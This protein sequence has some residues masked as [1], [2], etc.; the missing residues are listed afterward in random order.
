VQARTGR[1]DEV[2]EGPAIATGV[3]R[4]PHCSKAAAAEIMER[5]PGPGEYCPE[6]GEALDAQPSPLSS[7]PSAQAR[8]A[9]LWRSRLFVAPLAIA[10][11]G[12]I[13]FAFL[14][15]VTI[16]RRP[17]TGA[18]QVCRSSLTDRIAGDIVRTFAAKSGTAASRFAL[19]SGGACDLRFAAGVAR[20]DDDAVIGHDGIV[21]VVNRRNSV[22]ELTLAQVRAILTGEISDWGEV[23]GTKGKIVPMVPPD[24]SDEE[25]L[26]A[27]TLL[28]DGKLGGSVLRSH[29]SAAIVRALA[30]P[31]GRDGIGI[32]A[33]SAANPVKVVKL[34]SLPPPSTLSIADH[35]YPFSLSV[36]VRRE[37]AGRDP[38]VAHLLA[39]AQS[40]AAQALV[41]RDGLVAKEGF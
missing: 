20:T 21:V 23:G 38:V 34:P 25:Q 1:R 39:Y 7:S 13:G 9:P 22:R 32:V 18:I 10:L 14:H 31:G 15:P 26:L 30:G 19:V 4:N 27:A 29:S 35:R 24:G 17:V 12:A 40:D 33:F 8:R 2:T 37:R 16:Q 41:V 6:C 36:T 5:Y 28:Y 11:V 3:C